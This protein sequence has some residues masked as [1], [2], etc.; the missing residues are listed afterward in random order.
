MGVEGSRPAVWVGVGHLPEHRKGL[1]LVL[2]KPLKVGVKVMYIC[3]LSIVKFFLKNIF[4]IITIIEKHILVSLIIDL[5][6]IYSNLPILGE[7]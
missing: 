3:F 5:T 2:G 1:S 7:T 4:Y 6:S